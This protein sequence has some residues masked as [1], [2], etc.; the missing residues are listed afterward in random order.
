MDNFELTPE[1]IAAYG[2]YLKQEERTPATLEKYLR[3]V[4]A[5]ACWLNGAAVTKDAVTGWKER[6]L[7]ERRAPS[8]VNA[9]LSALNGLF[10][11]LGWEGCRARFV[12]V[13]RRLFRDPARELT[14]PDYERLIAAAREL[15]RERLA[16]VMETICA[17][18]VRV[19]EV[20]YFTVEA[21]RQGRAEISLKGKVRVILIPTKLARKLLKYAKKNKTASGEIFLT[22]NGKSL[23]RRQIWAEMKR[24]CAHAGVEPSKVFPHNL[25]HCFATAYYR[26]YKD[27]AKLADVLGHSSIETTRIYLLTSGAEHQR[28]L[29]RLG[30]VS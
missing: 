25:R 30:L 18:G 29:D 16:L 23:S 8:T 14:R 20:R 9:A 17:T 10:R 21:V 7:A 13:Q 22:G 24:L 4:R 27:I 12:K 5:F 2:L 19:S 3:D 1:R 15:G 11:F 6:L 26:A 28:Q